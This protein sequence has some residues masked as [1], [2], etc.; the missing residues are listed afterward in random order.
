MTRLGHLLNPLIWTDIL[1]SVT[2]GV[3]SKF[4]PLY[5]TLLLDGHTEVAKGRLLKETV[6]GCDS[7]TRLAIAETIALSEWKQEARRMGQ[8]SLRSLLTHASGIERLL[9]ERYWRESHL[10]EAA[11]VGGLQ[12]KAMSD[13]F[14]HAARVLLATVVNGCFPDG[15]SVM[16]RHAEPA[17]LEVATAVRDTM[18]ALT[19]M[20]TTG[21]EGADRALVFPIV[22]AAA[23]APNSPQRQ[24]F[25]DRFTR[26]G[27]EAQ[28]GNTQSALRLI[29]EVW[30]QRDGGPPGTEVCWRKVMFEL[31]DEGLLLI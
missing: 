30:R 29:N 1:T 23:H 6:M 9:E 12:R 21:V 10:I 15:T 28:F 20:D 25:L 31:D 3:A 8:L 5:R 11:D 27:D 17:V 2:E 4:L 14:Y 22:I 19:A 18:A 13:V 7:T 24:F 16:S 26:L